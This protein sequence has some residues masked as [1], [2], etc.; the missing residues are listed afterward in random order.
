[1]R[2]ISFVLAIFSAMLVFAESSAFGSVPA[3]GI[4]ESHYGVSYSTANDSPCTYSGKL[5]TVTMWNSNGAYTQTVLLSQ[6][7]HNNNDCLTQIV[8]RWYNTKTNTIDDVVNGN[9]TPGQNGDLLYTKNILNGWVPV[10]LYVYTE[11]D[12]STAPNFAS[13]FGIVYDANPCIADNSICNY[14]S[15]WKAHSGVI[16]NN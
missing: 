8:M 2:R 7:L 5:N 13:N 11:P 9:F 14:V 6:Y 10:F 4:Y 3:N 16:H 15:N 12:N 1:M